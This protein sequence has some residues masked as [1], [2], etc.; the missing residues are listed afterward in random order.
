MY[1]NII[2]LQLWTIPLCGA[3]AGT[4]GWL[5]WYSSAREKIYCQIHTAHITHKF[6][7]LFFLALQL[8]A[9]CFVTLFILKHPANTQ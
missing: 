3:E 6:D 7:A 2:S 5:R 1:I 9:N 4:V 8:I